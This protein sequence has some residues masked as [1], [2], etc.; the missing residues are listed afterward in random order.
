MDRHLGPSSTLILVGILVASGSP[1]TTG[2][3]TPRPAPRQ[4]ATAWAHLAHRRF[5]A[6]GNATVVVV[7]PGGV[8][9]HDLFSAT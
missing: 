4:Q 7:G 8:A 3:S 6:L 1:A 9:T 2:W 5:D